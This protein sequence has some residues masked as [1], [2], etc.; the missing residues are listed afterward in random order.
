MI[1]Q[2]CAIWLYGSRARGNSDAWSDLDIFAAVPLSTT[3]D[4]IQNL[5]PISLEAASFSRYSWNEILGMAT[6]GS[7]FLHH[8]N[9]EGYPLYE[10]PRCKGKLTSILSDLGNY[11]HAR[12]DLCG[13]NT[14]LYDVDEALKAKETEV[15]ELSV[16]ATV[17]RHCSILG[18]W[19]LGT[20]QF[21]RTE[22][23]SIVVKTLRLEPSMATEFPSLYKYRLYMDE[24]V[25]EKNLIALQ[26]QI[27]L[28]RAKTLIGKL[29]DIA[30]G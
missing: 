20:P 12:R 18:C 16:L 1:T 11:K 3:V 24:R 13:F 2:G 27:W 4:E 19:L 26:P 17:I 5:V 21:G 7:L 15:F 22:P 10:S 23:V 28:N 29:E 30:S 25:E 6:Y 9:L 8:L 14:V